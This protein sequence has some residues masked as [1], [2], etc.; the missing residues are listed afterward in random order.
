[1]ICKQILNIKVRNVIN[2]QTFN[3]ILTFAI[4][5]LTLF[6]FDIS[7]QIKFDKTTS[8]KSTK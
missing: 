3:F 1:M 8:P 6:S 2:F 5:F 4:A 7:A